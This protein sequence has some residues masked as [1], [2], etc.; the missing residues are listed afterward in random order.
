VGSILAYYLIGKL[1]RQLR[2]QRGMTQEELADGILSRTNLSRL[3]N[4][5]QLPHKDKLDVLLQRLGLNS[6]EAYSHYLSVKEFDFSVKCDDILSLIANNK[7]EEAETLIDE[8]SA[9]PEFNEGIKKQ[10]LLSYRAFIMINLKQDNY[11]I[12]KF[13]LEALQITIKSFSEKYISDYFLSDQETRLINALSITYLNDNNLVK[14]IE[15]LEKL[16]ESFEASKIDEE[17][18]FKLYSLVLFNL[19][20]YYGLN[21]RYSDAVNICDYAKE[22][23]LKTNNMRR[24]P[25]FIYNKAY[26]LCESGHKEECIPL[27]YQAY[28]GFDMMEDNYRSNIVKNHAKEKHGIDFDEN[29][30]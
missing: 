28:Y 12:R 16:K 17:Q 2:K 18:K 3:E 15:I 9:F 29:N 23:C 25:G 24:L 7:N 22:L 13:I 1:V 10:L 19:S 14:A 21:K 6:H 30:C 26:N 4:G 5:E 11:E 27:L 20:K 8:L